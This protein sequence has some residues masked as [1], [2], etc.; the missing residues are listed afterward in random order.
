MS[1]TKQTLVAIEPGAT[2]VSNAAEKLPVWLLEVCCCQSHSFSERVGQNLS[3]MRVKRGKLPVD[4]VSG[5]TNGS[6]LR[7]IG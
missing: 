5:A 6:Q 4:P 7:L 1:D 2:D 3:V